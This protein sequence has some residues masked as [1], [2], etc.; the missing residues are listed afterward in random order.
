M[1]PTA[2]QHLYNSMRPPE[3]LKKRDAPED[4]S[5]SSVGSPFTPYGRCLLPHLLAKGVNDEA[6]FDRYRK[7][8]HFGC[9]GWRR[10]GECAV[11]SPLRPCSNLYLASPHS[12]KPRGGPPRGRPAHYPVFRPDPSGTARCG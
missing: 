5:Y 1:E 3:Q 9:D 7:R 2:Y 4:L 6:R 11:L 12:P 8:G 10:Y